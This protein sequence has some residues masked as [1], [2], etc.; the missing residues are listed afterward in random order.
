MRTVI[1][2]ND[3]ARFVTIIRTNYA[4]FMNPQACQA[5]IQR[6]RVENQVM[7]E[8]L[9]SCGNS[10]IHV[11]NPSELA[12]PNWQILRGFS[13]QLLHTH[14]RT[15]TEVYRPPE[16]A[17]INNRIREHI[18]E[19]SRIER[20]NEELQ[21]L[22]TRQQSEMEE[23]RAR[24]AKS[25]E[26][27]LSTMR[28]FQSTQLE[29]ARQHRGDVEEM[30]RQKR[31]MEAAYARD[32]A[33]ILA[34]I[35]RARQEAERTRQREAEL[36]AQLNREREQAAVQMRQVMEQQAQTVAAQHQGGGG[37]G[38]KPNFLEK[39]VNGIGKAFSSIV[40]RCSVM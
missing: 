38:R 39:M 9:D 35:E 31:D 27:F 36:Q 40:P 30:A 25:E 8:I 26:N 12:H 29:L 23:T 34:S 37:G 7:R 20:Q 11:N 4:Q 16:L 1:F 18:E 22:L 33:E 28:E 21:Q 32:K 10:M 24:L 6:L 13:R 19:S 3:I 5:D 17:T 2:N 15:C 14:L